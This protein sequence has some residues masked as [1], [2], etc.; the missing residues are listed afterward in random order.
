MQAY[1]L[2]QLAFSLIENR[3]KALLVADLSDEKFFKMNF[4]FYIREKWEYV[5]KCWVI[6]GWVIV[7]YATILSVNYL[8]TQ[9]LYYTHNTITL[10]INISVLIR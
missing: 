10:I 8:L 6:S 9:L 7:A 1:F 2:R 5:I 3:L 4:S